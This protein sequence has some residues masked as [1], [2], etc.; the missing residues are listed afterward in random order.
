MN[1]LTIIGNLTRDPETRDVSGVSCCTFT[2]AVNRRVRAGAHP[3]A[4]YVRVTAWRGLADTCASYLTKGR[5]VCVVGPARAGGY[6]DRN[7]GSVHA[8]LEITADDVEFLGTRPREDGLTPTDD[9]PEEF[10]GE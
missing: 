2:V 8:Y 6:N 10:L 1:L 4:D 7:D 3:E 9:V 5:K